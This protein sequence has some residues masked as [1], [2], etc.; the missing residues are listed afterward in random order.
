V[1]SAFLWERYLGAAAGVSVDSDGSSTRRILSA[2]TFLMVWR[3]PLGQRISIVAAV[4]DPN[5]K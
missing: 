4:S 2:E 5:P 1:L 3:I